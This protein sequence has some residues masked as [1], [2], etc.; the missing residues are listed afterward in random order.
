MLRFL[1]VALVITVF[2]AGIVVLVF[3][4]VVWSKPI[5]YIVTRAVVRHFNVTPPPGA[6]VIVTFYLTLA[7][8][9]PNRRVSV[10][11][12]WVEFYVLYGEAV[13]LA[14]ANAPA[15]RQPHRNET[16]LDVRAMARSV[17]IAEQTAREL[18]HDLAAG[19]VAV[20]VRVR[21]GVQ[22]KVAGL[23]TRHCSLQT[24]CSP[25]VISLSP[26]SAWSF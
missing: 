20:D 5:E 26:S 17:P 4:L 18:E 15:F 19:E 25:V 21:A 13:Q 22:F 7:A 3:W 10:I 11:Y 14:V 2:L 8:N 23:K 16:L 12:D 9:N 6:T 24:F 1:V